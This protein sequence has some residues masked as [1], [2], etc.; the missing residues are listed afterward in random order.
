MNK[1]LFV[2]LMIGTASIPSVAV[3]TDM[4][5]RAGYDFI[6]YSGEHGTRK[7]IFSELK[8]NIDNGVAVFNLSEGRRN[9]GN[10]DSWNALRGHTTVWYNW[11][12][13]LSTKTALSISENTPVFSRRDAQQDVSIK[14]IP[15]TVFTLGYRYANYFGNTDVNAF[16]GGISL[17]TGPFIT[18]WRY[19]HYD[20]EDSG[21][22]YS[23][24]VSVR[25]NDMNG[26]GN[27]QLWM[28]RGTGAYTYDWSPD[29]KRGTL[30]SISLRR[31][32]PLTEVLTIGLTLGKQ[33]Y[34]TPVSSYHSQQVLTDITWQF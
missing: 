2:S 9:Y 12:Q 15:K 19:T 26:K 5:M 20:T 23:H 1:I 33:W 6:D 30:K 11:N 18:S 13:W 27:T 16:S 17:Y 3:A 29:T 32:Q 21:G 24:I 4:S 31:N 8:T 28:S 14:V 25:I 34:D 22:S 10:G 7:S